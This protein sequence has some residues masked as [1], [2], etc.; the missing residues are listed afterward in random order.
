MEK[1]LICPCW[2]NFVLIFIFS[3]YFFHSQIFYHFFHLPLSFLT[4]SRPHLSCFIHF[5]IL[6]DLIKGR[7][8]WVDSKLHMLCSVDLN[9]D[10]RKKVLQSSDYL[11]HP[12]ALTVFE[13]LQ[14]L[15]KTHSVWCLVFLSNCLNPHSLFLE[16]IL[17]F[18]FYDWNQGHQHH[19]CENNKQN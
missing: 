2:W 14:L 7:L 1:L 11:A 4:S 5:I 16:I 9:G 18:D 13:V 6:P 10:N 3:S 15:N 19:V 17:I 12:F 8:Y